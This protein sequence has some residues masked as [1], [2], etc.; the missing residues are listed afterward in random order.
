MNSR[1]NDTC[2]YKQKIQIQLTIQARLNN[3]P[4]VKLIKI[5]D[6]ELKNTKLEYEELLINLQNL[7]EKIDIA[8]NENGNYIAFMQSKQFITYCLVFLEID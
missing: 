6:S 2:F 8:T 1:Y 7:V 4:E 5:A 3:I